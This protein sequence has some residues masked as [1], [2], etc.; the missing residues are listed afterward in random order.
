MRFLHFHYIVK[1]FEKKVVILMDFKPIQNN[2]FCTAPTVACSTCSGQQQQQLAQYFLA[3]SSLIQNLV[4]R[5][6]IGCTV[7]TDIYYQ[8]FD[9]GSTYNLENFKGKQLQLYE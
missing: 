5:C 6:E 2:I 8:Q 7:L 1:C 9:V 3:R 4:Q